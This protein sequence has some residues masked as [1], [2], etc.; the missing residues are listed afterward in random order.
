[1]KVAIVLKSIVILMIAS[2]AGGCVSSSAISPAS[3]SVTTAQSVFSE[4]DH[5][6]VIEN[7]TS[8]YLET[9]GFV[10]ATVS[11]IL[12]KPTKS[13]VIHATDN[14]WLG[15][16]MVLQPHAADYRNNLLVR[17]L[18]DQITVNPLY[19]TLK[20]VKQGNMIILSDLASP[21]MN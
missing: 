2:V 15:H 5:C 4:A 18:N 21:F 10:G 12:I 19:H 7:Q 14:Q 3:S 6:F 8:S 17:G 20:I 1:M 11:T 16:L 13:L 9:S